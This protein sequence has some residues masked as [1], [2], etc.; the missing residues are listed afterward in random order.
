MTQRESA[1]DRL[2]GAIC[3]VE[4]AHETIRG[5]LMTIPDSVVFAGRLGLLTDALESLDIVTDDL[6]KTYDEAEANGD[7]DER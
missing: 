3:H 2:S 5:I 7:D 4:L 6:H 1:L